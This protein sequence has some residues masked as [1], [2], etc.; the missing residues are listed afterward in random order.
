MKKKDDKGRPLMINKAGKEV[1]DQR[2]YKAQKAAALIGKKLDDLTAA[3]ATPSTSAPAET[4]TSGEA[5]P[6]A[7]AFQVRASE[8]R[9]LV[10]RA[11]N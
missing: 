10:S 4:T 1:V 3:V 5:A 6:A 9:D 8:L 2:R 11:F 7:S